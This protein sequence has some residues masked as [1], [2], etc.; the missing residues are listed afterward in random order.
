ML[1]VQSCGKTNGPGRCSPPPH[2]THFQ[3]Q[4]YTVLR[5]TMGAMID[6]NGNMELVSREVGESLVIP[7]GAVHTWWNVGD[8]DVHVKIEWF[9]VESDDKDSDDDNHIHNQMR[10]RSY[11]DFVQ[12]LTG[13]LR[14]HNGAPFFVRLLVLLDDFGIEPELPWLWWAALRQSI[15]PLARFVGYRSDYKEYMW[16]H[17]DLVPQ[18]NSQT[19]YDDL[20]LDIHKRSY[21]MVRFYDWLSSFFES[22]SEVDFVLEQDSPEVV[23]EEL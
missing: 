12:Q 23:P 5:G 19:I 16:K 2:I 18:D 11:Y 14:D 3:K 22:Y 20:D 9:P 6:V 13:I 17:W 10:K 7:A 8:S 4:Q 21:M 1:F 15:L